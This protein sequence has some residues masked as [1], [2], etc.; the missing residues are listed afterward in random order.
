MAN[1][2]SDVEPAYFSAKQV[3]SYTGW[4]LRTVRRFLALPVDPMPSIKVGQSVRIPIAPLQEWL[5]RHRVQPARDAAAEVVD[6]LM[7]S[8]RA[9]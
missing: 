6:D 1:K 3:C 4:G 2:V 5:E 8:L 9:S 7:K